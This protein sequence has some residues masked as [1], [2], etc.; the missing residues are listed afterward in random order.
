[1]AHLFYDFSVF[2]HL[3][4]STEGVTPA[5]RTFV[6]LPLNSLLFS[7]P[8]VVTLALLVALGNRL[9]SR[10]LYRE[11]TAEA[12]T[13]AGAVTAE[14]VAVLVS[15]RARLRV[16]IRTLWRFGFAA[17]QRVRQ[18]HQA[19]LRLGLTRWYRARH[20]WDQPEDTEMRMRELRQSPYPPGRRPLRRCVRQDR[21]D[22]DRPA[23][24]QHGTA[25][26]HLEQDLLLLLRQHPPVL[27]LGRQRPLRGRWRRHLPGVPWPAHDPAVHRA[28]RNCRGLRVVAR[29][30]QVGGVTGYRPA[31]PSMR[32]RISPRPSR[33]GRGPAPGGRTPAIWRRCGRGTPRCCAGCSA[34]RWRCPGCACP[35][36]PAG[37]PAPPTR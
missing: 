3:Q 35:A 21:A 36:G 37:R 17:Y 15:P 14:E 4:I 2:A 32:S 20:E 13:G 5:I 9:E 31:L 30:P 28:L 22:A 26:D 33:R 6:L 18:L 29:Y 1:M 11:L 24:P 16:R 12:D 34:A 8:A 10:G 27:R 25:P 7:S 23:K 19:Q